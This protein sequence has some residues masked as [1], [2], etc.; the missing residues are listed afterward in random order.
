MEV[1]YEPWRIIAWADASQLDMFSFGRRLDKGLCT[2]SVSIGSRLIGCVF[3]RSLAGHA[4]GG[5]HSGFFLRKQVKRIFRAELKGT[6]KG[7][8]LK[9]Y[10]AVSMQGFEL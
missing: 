7:L 8:I 6:D 1:K 4:I 3:L 9:V 5:F 10:L 2:G